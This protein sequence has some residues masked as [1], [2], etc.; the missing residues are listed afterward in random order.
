VVH[1][2]G[3]L[4]IIIFGKYRLYSCDSIANYE[5]DINA[6]IDLSQL[7]PEQVPKQE[8]LRP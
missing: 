3:V 4:C 7:P 1:W 2:F 6:G 5:P 8:F